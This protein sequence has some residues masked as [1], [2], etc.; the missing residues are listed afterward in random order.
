MCKS[1]L[2]ANHASPSS[3]WIFDSSLAPNGREFDNQLI[4]YCRAFDTESKW[5]RT[6]ERQRECCKT[7]DL[8]S[9]YSEFTWEYNQLPTFRKQNLKS[10]I[11]WLSREHEQLFMNRFSFRATCHVHAPRKIEKKRTRYIQTEN[12]K[13]R[14]SRWRSHPICFRSMCSRLQT[15]KRIVF[16]IFGSTRNM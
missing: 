9:E 1:T 8:I 2:K 5:Q 16:I 15:P 14:H 11:L 10:T 12:G 7:I 6:L 13:T 4:P 3:P